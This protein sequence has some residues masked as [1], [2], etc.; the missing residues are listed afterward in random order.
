MYDYIRG[1][2]VQ[3]KPTQAVV[4]AGG[5][6]FL[7]HIPLSTFSAH[8]KVGHEV[9]FFLTPIYREDSQRLFGFINR[10]ERES[11]EKLS[12]ISGIGPKT[13]LSLIGHMSLRDLNSAIQ[14][15]NAKL[16]AKVPGIGKKTAERIIVEMR[17]KKLSQPSIPTGSIVSEEDHLF[18]DGINALIHLGYQDQKA[19]QVIE[20]V[21]KGQEEHPLTLEEVIKQALQIIG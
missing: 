6:G 8:L 11:F 2:L 5:M 7:I 12:H 20:K 9:Q 16:I 4:E 19:Y 10:E 3:L 15:S 18:N 21:M 14:S 13:A 1:T 17:D